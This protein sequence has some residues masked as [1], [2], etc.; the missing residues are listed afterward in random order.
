[1]K[2]EFLQFLEGQ[3]ELE[4]VFIKNLFDCKLSITFKAI[5]LIVPR[6]P[7]AENNF[8]YAADNGGPLPNGNNWPLK[9]GAHMHAMCRVRAIFLF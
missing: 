7:V 6:Q 9:V 1:M 3:K 8:E 4:E 2:I 5:F